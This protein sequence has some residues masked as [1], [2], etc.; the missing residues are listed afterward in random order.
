MCNKNGVTT[1]FWLDTRCLSNERRSYYVHAV[2]IFSLMDKTVNVIN[3]DLLPPCIACEP[4]A[5]VQNSFSDVRMPVWRRQ[6]C[7]LCY[8]FGVLLLLM[9]QLDLLASVECGHW[10]V[11]SR[12]RQQPVEYGG[13][14]LNHATQSRS[15]YYVK[16][17]F[18]PTQIC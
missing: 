1:T 17:V 12:E 13:G 11:T 14:P 8:S 15:S 10:D 6:R 3:A 16:I 7:L 18:F 5:G 4:S 9:I 2:S